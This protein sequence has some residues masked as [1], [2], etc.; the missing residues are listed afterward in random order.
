MNKPRPS[1]T[2]QVRAT[3]LVAFFLGSDLTTLRCEGRRLRWHGL[4]GGDHVVSDHRGRVYLVDLVCET[5]ALNVGCYPA[6]M[7]GR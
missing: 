7:V 4:N 3:S 2:S 6:C 5:V 1:L